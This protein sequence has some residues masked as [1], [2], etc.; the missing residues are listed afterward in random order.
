MIFFS[1]YLYLVASLPLFLFISC[2][3]SPKNVDESLTMPWGLNI[4][5]VIEKEYP[6]L[7]IHEG[8]LSYGT[9]GFRAKGYVLPPVAARLVL[10]AVLRGAYVLTQ[11]AKK[12]EKIVH[13]NSHLFCEK[14]YLSTDIEEINMCCDIGIMITASHNPHEDNGFKIIDYNGQSVPLSWEIWSTKAVNASSSVNYS[15]I[16]HQCKEEMLQNDFSV[17]NASRN[18]H[19][20]VGTD[21]RPSGRKICSAITHIL[22]LVGVTHTVLE[23]ISTPQLHEVVL[24]ANSSNTFRVP[25][26]FYEEKILQSFETLFK[27]ARTR[28]SQVLQ[29]FSN[30][31]LPS[32]KKICIVIDTSNGVGGIV[33]KRLLDH[34]KCS[35]IKYFDVKL[36]NTDVQNPEGLNNS[37]GAD[38]VNRHHCPSAEMKSIPNLNPEVFAEYSDVHFY[39]LDGDAD[40]VVALHYEKNEDSNSSWTLMDGDRLCI[41]FALL[42]RQ[43]LGTEVL[44]KLD[45]GIVQTAYANGASTFFV[46][47]TLKLKTYLAATGV[48]NIHPVAQAHDIGVYFEANGHGTMLFNLEKITAALRSRVSNTFELECETILEQVRQMSLLVSQ[49]CGDAIGDFLMCEVALEALNMSFKDLRCLYTDFPALQIKV[50]VPHPK[51]II[52]VPDE[53]RA[54]SP[55]GLQE[56][57]NA[58]VEETKSEL[59]SSSDNFKIRPE[60]PYARCFARASG[61]ESIVRVYCEATTQASCEALCKSVCATVRKFCT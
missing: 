52:T 20:F 17:E 38:Y 45:I 32:K 50:D 34:P 29:N 57:I 59:L 31:S 12:R 37:C 43:W 19:I 44:S 40:R 5:E 56:E 33:L 25:S 35:L 47:N 13:G 39:S 30:S 15:N 16:L 6:L 24:Y 21:T 28:R 2:Y 48:K 7:H 55:P 3:C 54:V 46:E 51:R 14:E 9:A 23:H 27:A 26:D 10:I 4:L 58:A 41:L 60:S 49:V 22:T 1:P 53:T 42:L 11:K 36:I 61:T 8:E 18:I